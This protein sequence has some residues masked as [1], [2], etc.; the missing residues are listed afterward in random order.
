LEGSDLSTLVQFDVH[1]TANLS[2]FGKKVSYEPPADYRPLEDL[3]DQL[4]EGLE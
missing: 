3:F 2:E 1:A 4:F